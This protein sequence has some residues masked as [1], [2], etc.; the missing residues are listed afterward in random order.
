MGDFP[1]SLTAEIGHRPWPLPERP[2]IMTQSWHDL[3][4]AH[5]PV[6]VHAL[7]D[8]LPHGLEPDLF[9]RQAWLG[10]VPF[11]MTNVAPRGVPA[12]PWV[13][14]FAELNV[15][16]YVSVGGKPGVFFFSLDAG[17]PLAVAAAR[18]LFKLPYYA[19]E[20]QVRRVDGSVAYDSRRTTTRTPP[21]YFT[22][23][24]R[25]VAPP[26]PARQG[27]LEHFLTER[28]CLYLVDDMLRMHRLEIHH[29]PWLLQ[30]AEASID[31]NTM[32]EA[33]G[34]RLTSAAPLLHYA[35]RQDVLVWP[36]AAI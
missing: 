7:Q 25:P 11:D 35:A 34:I 31:Q 17:N 4:F 8:L 2:W 33:S 24:Y 32:A 14:A 26:A 30:P 36:L 5:W 28:Y 23:R 29:R 16:T 20:M 19:A 22:A 12:L 18:T 1:S 6:P 3:L 27:T 15:R 10:V 13:S 21:A 9:D